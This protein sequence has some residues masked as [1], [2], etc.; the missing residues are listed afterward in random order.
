MLHR[1]THH[2]RRVCVWCF[3]QTIAFPIEHLAWEKAPILSQITHVLG[4]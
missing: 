3:M 1:C 4:L 2:G